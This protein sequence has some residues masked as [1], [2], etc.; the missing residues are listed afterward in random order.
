MREFPNNY[1]DLAIVDPPYGIGT[2]AYTPGKR[3]NASG[4]GF[5]DKYE[6][7]AAVYSSAQSSKVKKHNVEHNRLSNE[8]TRGFGD[9]NENPP[10]EY[11]AELFRVSKS[12]IIWGG[13]YFILPP[14]RNFIVWRKTTV[15]ESFSMAMCEYAWV[16]IDGNSKYIELAPQGTASDPRIHPTQKPIALYSWILNT[17]AKPGDKILDTHVGSAS[18]LIAC[19]RAGYDYIG[20]EIDK[21]YY[22]KAMER[23]EA[24]K[25]QLS[26]FDR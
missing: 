12:Q 25:A 23:L 17:Y 15:A 24:A 7:I 9:N 4:Q 14:S 20:F 26:I 11:F 2:L 6:I 21:N 16:S 22:D 8:T 13:N 5:I 1:F 3:I 10:P 19:N 18:S